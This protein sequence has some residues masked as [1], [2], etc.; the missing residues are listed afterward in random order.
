MDHAGMLG[1]GRLGFL[2]SLRATP[3]AECPSTA[4]L[5]KDFSPETES[6]PLKAD[7]AAVAEDTVAGFEFQFLHPP[8]NGEPGSPS[9]GHAAGSGQGG[10]GKAELQVRPWWK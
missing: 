8:P 4:I 6:S 10:T 1:I 2:I 3:I 9:P 5:V 7:P